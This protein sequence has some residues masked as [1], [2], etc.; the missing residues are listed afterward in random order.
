MREKKI[1]PAVLDPEL[2]GIKSQ[3]RVDHAAAAKLKM[4]ARLLFLD[5]QIKK[6]DTEKPSQKTNLELDKGNV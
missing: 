1:L 4:A 3:P 6:I 5:N 2:T